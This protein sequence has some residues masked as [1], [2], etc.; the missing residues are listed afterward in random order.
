MLRSEHRVV[1]IDLGTTNSVI[2]C[3]NETGVP[4][5][6][7]DPEGDT[8]TPSVVSFE[9]DKVTVGRA[10]MWHA[11]ERPARVVSEIKRDIGNRLYRFEYRDRALNAET[12][13]ALILKKLKQYAE[14]QIGPIAGAV[15]GVPNYFDDTRRK[16][17]EAAGRIAG[18]NV[19]D[20]V[21]EPVA[22][23]LCYA[24]GRGQITRKD[25]PDLHAS[26]VPSLPPARN[27]DGP[28]PVLVY[29]L[30]GGTFDVAFVVYDPSRFHVVATDG[31]VRLGG[32]DW[33]RRL[34][35]FAAER[36]A[37]Q[38]NVDL[39]QDVL[40]RLRLQRVAEQAK[41]ELSEQRVA[42]LKL[43]SG[44]KELK[45]KVTR[46][47][48]EELT[49][50]LLRRTETTMQDVLDEADVAWDDLADIVL[51]GGASRMPMVRRMIER[52]S[53]W[54]TDA[55]LP[56]AEPI[57][58]GAAIH[59]EL[60]QGR[61]R[62]HPGKTAG[63]GRIAEV[64]VNAHSLGIAVH[65]P[66][67]GELRSHVMIKRNTALPHAVT[68]R[69][70]TVVPNQSGA[71]VQVLEGESPDPHGCV[72]V[73]KCMLDQLPAGLPVGSPIDVTY[74]YDSS[75]RVHVHAMEVTGGHSIQNEIFQQAGLKNAEID[76]LRQFVASIPVS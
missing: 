24:Y 29:D 42:N 72:C 17:T 61:N 75:G 10:A 64:N 25:A 43:R 12:I 44:D 65:D 1:G 76:E 33:T 36:F 73:G 4:V 3:L 18:L 68:R 41:I 28:R 11:L 22:T 74:G 21:N 71:L 7:R 47:Q 52:V 32:T 13:S 2:A 60:V 70:L 20:I 26:E 38:H 48:F 14:A 9:D 31:D 30:G 53:G 58:L 34:A 5:A 49:A 50:D 62:P 56:A 19:L 59:A 35:D 40:D 46:E 45:L 57:A 66:E 63:L 69:F 37:Q 6:I 27:G 8:M 23:A 16:A 55:G 39:R 51:V 15:I 67:T 54:L